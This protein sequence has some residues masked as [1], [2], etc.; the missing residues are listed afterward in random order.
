[1]V[2]ESY[3]YLRNVPVE[4][5]SDKM[6]TNISSPVL[7]LDVSVISSKEMPKTPHIFRIMRDAETPCRL[8]CLYSRDLA[9]KDSQKAKHTL[10]QAKFHISHWKWNNPFPQLTRINVPARKC[11]KLTSETTGLPNTILKIMKFDSHVCE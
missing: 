9:H 7:A 5:L 2:L 6:Q 11:V 1:M 8:S 3:Y 4:C 10:G